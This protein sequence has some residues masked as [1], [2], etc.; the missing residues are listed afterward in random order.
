M[1]YKPQFS[2][3]L[4]LL[5]TSC[6]ALTFYL[7]CTFHTHFITILIR[8]TVFTSFSK[9]FRATIEVENIVQKGQDD[10]VRQKKQTSLFYS[11]TCNFFSLVDNFRTSQTWNGAFAFVLVDFNFRLRRFKNGKLYLKTKNLL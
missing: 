8:K 6:F 3:V 9:H 5:I 1:Y 11:H 4:R 10:L 2:S 7:P